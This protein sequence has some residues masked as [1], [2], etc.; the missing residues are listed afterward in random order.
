VTKQAGDASRL[1]RQAA[2]EGAD[3]VI[4]YGGDGTVM[5]VATGLRGTGVPMGVLP[6]GTANV[7]ALELGLPTD[8]AGAC[9]MLVSANTIVRPVDMI[10]VGDQAFLVRVSCGLEAAMVEGADREKKDRMGWLAYAL[11]GLQALRDP[12]PVRYR[13]T[14]DGLPVE[15]EGLTC[16][17]A[18]SGLIGKTTF[19]LAPNVSV[20][21]GILDLLVIRAAD[22]TSV[23]ALAAS[24]VSGGPEPEPLLH[25]QA[26]EI[27][28]EASVEQ[29]VQGDGELIGTT[30]VSVHVLPG[31]VGVIVPAP[32]EPA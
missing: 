30:P 25:W 28:V 27:T 16:M 26:R 13:L 2:D 15:A 32:A 4:A 14:L 8:L 6:G 7:V 19:S 21:D 31:A 3:A 1:A 23:V 5:E 12:Q 20:Y 29:T 9:A 17:V 22:L 11:A 24:V 10:G 18:N